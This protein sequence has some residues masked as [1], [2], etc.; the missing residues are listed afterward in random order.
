MQE[1]KRS[2]LTR[3]KRCLRFRMNRWTKS[4]QLGRAGSTVTSSTVSGTRPNHESLY[5]F[6]LVGLE[7][8]E[9]DNMMHVFWNNRNPPQTN[10]S[11]QQVIFGK[12]ERVEG[13]KRRRKLTRDAGFHFP[14]GPKG[15]KAVN[16]PHRFHCHSDSYRL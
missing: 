10:R 1:G 6:R 12:R 15:E 11:S 7:K 14:D 9:T 3:C 16:P 5:T 8:S 2:S 4:R 13:G